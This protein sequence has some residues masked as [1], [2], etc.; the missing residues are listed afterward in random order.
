[1][2]K[3]HQDLIAAE[4][5]EQLRHKELMMKKREQ[6]EQMYADLW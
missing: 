1:M 6:E 2:S 4:R 3:R 5:M